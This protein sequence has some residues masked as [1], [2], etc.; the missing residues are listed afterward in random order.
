M[1][2][3]ERAQESEVVLSDDEYSQIVD[4]A[5]DVIQ[6]MIPTALENNE[7]TEAQLDAFNA[8]LESDNI[9]NTVT[10]PPSDYWLNNDTDGLYDYLLDEKIMNQYAEVT[11]FIKDSSE[12][13]LSKSATCFVILLIPISAVRQPNELSDNAEIGLDF[14]PQGVDADLD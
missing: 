11:I 14:Y 10:I 12:Q 2:N 8:N 9:Y 5:Y 7:L 6:Q 1:E 3:E 13:E 4:I